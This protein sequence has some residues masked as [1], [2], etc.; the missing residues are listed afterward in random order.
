MR[1]IGLPASVLLAVSVMA[2]VGDARA[3]EI[4]GRIL[5]SSTGAGVPTAGV[6]L[7]DREK[8]R[9]RVAVADSAGRYLLRVPE[10]GSYFLYAQR[11]GY[12]ATE[13]PLVAVPAQGTYRV[14]LE[15]R[16]EPIA[17]DPLLVSVRNEELER[18][19]TLRL[20]TNPNAVFGYRAIQGL[21]LE[22]A[23]LKSEDNTELLRWLSI[24]VSH[25]RDVCLGSR[26][27]TVERGTQEIGPPQC[28]TLYV[29]G[30]KVPQ[31]HVET[32]DMESIAVVVTF[33]K[34]RSVHFFTRT[35]DWSERPVI[36]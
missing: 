9:V 35:F 3:Q 1:V 10:A 7:L 12:H 15:L 32:V 27:P 33:L 16:P 17:L 20:G 29:D 23:K 13:S 36:R 28:G 22:E 5:D 31:E 19:W 11:L 24:P 8:E 25:G 21:E 18:W 2:P 34:P 26:M 14:D 6:F 30:V 4:T